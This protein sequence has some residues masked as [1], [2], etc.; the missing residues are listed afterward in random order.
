MSLTDTPKRGWIGLVAALA[1]AGIAAAV[2][3]IQ[4]PRLLDPERYRTEILQAA[5]KHLHRDLTFSRA[6]F[7]CR[8][9]PA[10]TIQGLKITD[11][12]GASPLL[13]VEKA[14]LHP[15]LLPLLRGRVVLKSLT[16]D[17]PR[18]FVVRGPDGRFNIADLL[19]GPPTDP[20]RQWRIRDGQA[21]FLD[22]RAGQ[23]GHVTTLAGVNLRIDDWRRGKKTALRLE[24]RLSARSL[25][26]AAPAFAHAGAGPPGGQGPEPPPATLSLNGTM[27]LAGRDEPLSASRFDGRLRL[28]GLSLDQ[29][30]PYGAAFGA[31]TAAGRL[32]L[33]LTG[34]GAADRF[35]VRVEAALAAPN[36]SW[37][38]VFSRPLTPD[39]VRIRGRLTRAPGQWALD[40]ARV[41]VDRL[42]L[43]G[44]FRLHALDTRDP[45]LSAR[46]SIPRLSLAEAKPYI[47]F[48]LLPRDTGN[49]FRNTLRQAVF[50]DVTGRLQGRLSRIRQ[51]DRGDNARVLA[52][53]SRVD[54]GTLSFGPDIPLVQD[55]AGQIR[56]EG[57]DILFEGMTGRIGASPFRLDGRITDYPLDA[58]SRYP[59][60][61]T[62]NP[63]PGEVK[64]LLGEAGGRLQYSGAS[65]MQLSGDGAAGDY[66]LTGAWDATAADY[67]FP[68]IL[69][70]PA[71]VSNRIRAVLRF[72]PG[73]VRIQDMKFDLAA[74]SATVSGVIPLDRD[75]RLRLNVRTGALPIEQMAPYIPRLK[76]YAPSGKIRLN[77]GARGG[78]GAETLRWRGRISVADAGFRPP[79]GLKPVRDLNGTLVLTGTGLAADDL[80]ARLGRTS[81][82]A[83]LRLDDWTNP[84]LQV[85]LRAPRLDLADAGLTH[86]R[87]DVSLRDVDL[88]ADYRN[89]AWQIRNLSATLNQTTLQAQGVIQEKPEPRADLVLS[90]PFLDVD[91]VAPLTEIEG[92]GWT[93]Q[94]GPRPWTVV[95]KAE[96]GRN[97][98]LTFSNL[99]ARIRYENDR[100]DIADGEVDLFGGKAQAEGRIDLTQAG[101]P[102]YDTRFSLTGASAEQATAALEMPDGF[103][104]GTFTLGG[105]VQ[106]AG[107]AREDLIRTASGTLNFKAKDGMIRKFA[108]LSKIFSI[109]NVSQLFKFQLPDMVSGGMPY[110]RITARLSLADGVIVTEDLFIRSN[111]MN[112]SVVGKTDLVKGVTEQTV[113]VQ[114]LQTVDKVVRRIPVVGWILSGEDG[115]VL[116]VYFEARGPLADPVVRAVP[117][118][119]LSKGLLDTFR[120]L[121][122]LP[123]RLFTDTGEVLLGR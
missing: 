113:G 105:Q 63:R 81:V 44:G 52:V 60:T 46:V 80:S 50:T 25:S 22:R 121:F 103:V 13:S 58:P 109:L 51:M 106:A 11:R 102:A 88:R 71:G 39:G 14:S 54:R 42:R 59:L 24:S 92:E 95:L 61:A 117:V 41:D 7:S 34:Q 67:Q 116:T 84:A 85:G 66:R 57:T 68:G 3:Y 37:P 55:V 123:A 16:L 20:V 91:D 87:Q 23:N 107:S 56:L 104:T 15:A 82:A 26:R 108:V 77:L 120:N 69:T 6:E 30:R 32:D 78:A 53:R 8:P 2:L 12:D 93:A 89:D 96:S 1:L 27:T 40:G 100:I 90:F 47:P 4:L 31:P 75:G 110:S 83:S 19:E 35:D 97:K 94:A 45:I 36:V 86:P 49:F 115:R 99:S 43:E 28:M 119:F 18:L 10:L 114:P 21:V 76:P 112:I 38:A 48:G 65:V 122:Q 118:R 98:A 70:K 62:L 73:S 17:R 9:V 72:P 74:L 101:R 29:F 5:R 33:S 64:W 79:A 111:A